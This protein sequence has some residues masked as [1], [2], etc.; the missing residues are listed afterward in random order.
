MSPFACYYLLFGHAELKTDAM[1]LWL[2]VNVSDLTNEND[3]TWYS[4]SYGLIDF[5]NC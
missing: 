3:F 4:Y 2:E 1:K 5:A